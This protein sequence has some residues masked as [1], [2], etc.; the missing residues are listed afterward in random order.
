M[1]SVPKLFVPWCLV[2]SSCDI[3]A[4]C[5][6]RCYRLCL[7]PPADE[8]NRRLVFLPP[9]SCGSVGAHRVSVCLRPP[10]RASLLE[11][12][13]VTGQLGYLA[14]S[15]PMW[16]SALCCSRQGG[17]RNLWWRLL[18]TGE[19]GLRRTRPVPHM[20]DC[21]NLGGTVRR[22]ALCDEPSDLW[23]SAGELGNERQRLAA[24]DVAMML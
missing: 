3:C 10:G 16:R 2:C 9:W 21:R 5:D 18:R 6:C 7:A 8:L 22:K 17:W 20:W 14:C 12:R 11:L 23:P 1:G 24:G 15:A 19:L 13:F 4:G